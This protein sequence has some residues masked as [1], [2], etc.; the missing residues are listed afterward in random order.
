[1]GNTNSVS[2]WAIPI[3]LIRKKNGGVRLCVNYGRVNQL[4]KPDGFPLPRIPDCLDS[5]AGLN[6]FSTFD[7]TRDIFRS[8]L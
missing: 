1:M 3:V 5:V 6:L 8:P 2:S 4:V 7:L